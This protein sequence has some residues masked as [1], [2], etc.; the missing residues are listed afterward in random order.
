MSTD[1]YL[2]ILSWLP[3]TWEPHDPH[4]EWKLFF[5]FRDLGREW[6]GGNCR[7]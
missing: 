2:F 7:K 4:N 5:P 6:D 3:R 1:T